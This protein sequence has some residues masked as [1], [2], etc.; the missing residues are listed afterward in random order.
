MSLWTSPVLRRQIFISTCKI[1]SVNLWFW[2]CI[3]GINFSAFY[4][5]FCLRSFRWTALTRTHWQFGQTELTKL[6]QSFFTH[7][8]LAPGSRLIESA[9]LFCLKWSERLSGADK[10][11][12]VR[13]MNTRLRKEKLLPFFLKTGFSL[14]IVEF[15]DFGCLFGRRGFVMSITIFRRNL[16][17]ERKFFPSVGWFYSLESAKSEW[18]CSRFF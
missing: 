13:V 1:K 3:P 17:F 10:I 18:T 12:A 14:T 15:W 8:Q 9:R 2:L 7:T 6:Y 4:Q 16:N 5:K 11:R